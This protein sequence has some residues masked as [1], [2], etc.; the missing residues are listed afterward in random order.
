[1]RTHRVSRLYLFPQRKLTELKRENIRLHVGGSSL[2]CVLSRP[3]I[4]PI[5]AVIL[6]HPHPLYGGDK[7][8]QVVKDLD[9]IFLG[10]GYTTL[11]LD[12]RGVTGGYA[13]VAGAVEDTHQAIEL[14]ESYE[15]LT[16]GL[17]GYSFGGSTALRVVSSRPVSFLVCLSASFDLFLEG[18]HNTSSLSQIHC[19]AL[20][21]HGQSDTF[22]PHTDLQMFA[23]MIAGAR[24][25][26]LQNENHFYQI[27]MQIVSDEIRSFI[28]GLSTMQPPERYP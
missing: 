11:R 3:D 12:F 1:M 25:V 24:A 15:P 19:P 28:S 20:L 22:V 4:Q 13:G 26:S 21:F 8:N 27:S 5:G 18:G 9:K 6:L 14:L 23:R 17:A 10:M 16:L 2:T 7:D